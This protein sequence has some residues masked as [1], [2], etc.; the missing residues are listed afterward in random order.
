MKKLKTIFTVAALL[1][2]VT[3]FAAD[4]KGAIVNENVKASFKKGFSTA[5]NI[6]WEKK[7]DV[8]FANFILNNRSAEAAFNENGDLIALSNSIETSKMPLA[9]TVAISTEY[10]GYEVA[11]KAT[12]IT[13]EFQTNY[14]ISISNEKQLLKLKCAANGAIIVEQKQKIK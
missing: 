11:T 6:S 3:T 1:F 2:T 8:Y 13:Y 4:N 12:E 5:T 9:I 10:P 7:N 14:Y